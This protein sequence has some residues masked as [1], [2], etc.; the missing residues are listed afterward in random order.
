MI[1]ELCCANQQKHCGFE[2]SAW[3]LMFMVIWRMKGEAGL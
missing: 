1:L 3:I 2:T